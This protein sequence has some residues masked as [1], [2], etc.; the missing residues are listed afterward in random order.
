MREI[1][2]LKWQQFTHCTLYMDYIYTCLTFYQ[3][4]LTK[5]RN[6]YDLYHVLKQNLSK[7]GFVH[8]KIQQA[9]NENKLT[10]GETKL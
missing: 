9:S 5:N 7:Y 2:D 8:T 4:I 6:L 10:L 3:F 1:D